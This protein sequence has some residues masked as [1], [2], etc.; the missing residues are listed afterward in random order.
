MGSRGHL[1]SGVPTLSPSPLLLQRA[2]VQAGVHESTPRSHRCRLV[3]STPLL[4]LTEVPFLNSRG[5]FKYFL[6]PPI[7]IFIPPPAF[8][9][10]IEWNLTS[11]YRNNYLSR[12]FHD[13]HQISRCRNDEGM[14]HSSATVNVSV[15][16]QVKSYIVNLFPLFLNQRFYFRLIVPMLILFSILADPNNLCG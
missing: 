2:G 16:V 13:F 3:P 1:S 15:L 8:H 11:K 5:V 6:F 14:S 12:N 4:T 7:L 10:D 9:A